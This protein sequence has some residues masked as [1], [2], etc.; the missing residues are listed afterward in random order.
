MKLFKKKKKPKDKKDTKECLKSKL[1]KAARLLEEI[2]F[3]KQIE[4]LKVAED[5]R[6]GQ[7]Y[8]VS[9]A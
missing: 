9:K 1:D 7:Q 3:E 8:K 6:F 2:D 5:E 4:E